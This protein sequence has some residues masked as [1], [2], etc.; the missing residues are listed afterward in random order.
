MVEAWL[1]LP[2]FPMY[3]SLIISLLCYNTDYTMDPKNSVIMRFQ[4]NNN[5]NNNNDRFNFLNRF[6]CFIYVYF[7]FIFSLF[8]QNYTS[9]D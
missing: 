3:N 2:L 5:N 8:D 4:C 6:I 7:L 9:R 1:P